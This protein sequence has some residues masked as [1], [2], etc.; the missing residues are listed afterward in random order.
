MP[1]RDIHMRFRDVV[2]VNLLFAA[3][4]KEFPHFRSVNSTGPVQD[5]GN[6]GREKLFLTLKSFSTNFP[7]T[8][9]DGEQLVL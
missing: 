8:A 5:G 2:S 9:V 6:Q 3:L 1:E 7:H 4:E